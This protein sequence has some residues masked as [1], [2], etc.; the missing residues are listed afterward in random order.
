LHIV[1]ILANGDTLPRVPL[2]KV[3][4]SSVTAQVCDLRAN[5][6]SRLKLL[7]G[8]IGIPSVVPVECG[9]A[10]VWEEM[11]GFLVTSLQIMS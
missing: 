5:P 8:D 6:L 9:L 4:A 2:G 7:E 1:G 10:K 11:V 3:S